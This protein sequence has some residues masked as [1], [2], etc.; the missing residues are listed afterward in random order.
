MIV[1]LCDE[2]VLIINEFI[3]GDEVLL[4]EDKVMSIMGGWDEIDV[5]LF[6]FYS[7]EDT[8]IVNVEYH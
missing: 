2:S 4:A 6:Y 3:N 1:D 5:D 7:L 8:L